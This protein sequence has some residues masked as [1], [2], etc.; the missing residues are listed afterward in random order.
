MEDAALALAILGFAVGILF[1]L[2]ILLSVVALLLFVSVLFSVARGFTFLE[3]ALAVMAAQ[4]IVQ[5]AY[6]LGL[7]ARAA[8]T[9][10]QCPRPIL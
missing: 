6:F 9:A 2:K 5:G 1:R 4:S 10:A 3:T 8:F 7:I